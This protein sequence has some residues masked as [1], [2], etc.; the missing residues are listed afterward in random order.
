MKRR[1]KLS[2]AALLAV[3]MICLFQI[4]ETVIGLLIQPE[5][6]DNMKAQIAELPFDYQKIFDSL[7]TETNDPRLAEMIT[8][9]QSYPMKYLELLASNLDTFD[10]VYNYPTHFNT[11]SLSLDEAELTNGIPVLFQWDERWG[12]SVYGEDILA[13]TGCGPTVLSMVLSYLCQDLSITPA[14]VADYAQNNGYY[15]NGQGTLWSLFEDYANLHGITC[16]YLLINEKVIMENL[17]AGIPLI[18]SM[19]PGDFTKTGHFI[20]LC[21]VNDDSTIRV[22]D[23]NSKTRTEQQWDIDTLLPQIAA[24]WLFHG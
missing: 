10:F 24:G 23:P 11:L 3:L 22:H 4:S 1:V 21:G 5:I 15:I 2:R 17:Q 12:Y 14:S 13:L 19:L 18:V 9:Y 7:L 6:N 20:V 16:E 8:M